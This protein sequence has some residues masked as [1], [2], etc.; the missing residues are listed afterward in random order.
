MLGVPV[1]RPPPSPL[2]NPRTMDRSS[3]EK[4]ELRMETC[5]PSKPVAPA[6]LA[7]S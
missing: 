5:P 4:L 6:V 1:S 2:P 7:G 3:L